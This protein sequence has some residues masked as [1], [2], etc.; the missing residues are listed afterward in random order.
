[1]FNIYFIKDRPLTEGPEAPVPIT[2]NEWEFNMLLEVYKDKHPLNVLEVGTHY[3]GTLYHW[4][5][6]SS[7]FSSIVSVDDYQLNE[8][9]YA[10]WIDNPDCMVHVVKGKSQDKNVISSVKRIAGNYDFIFIDA[11]HEYEEVKADW[12]NYGPLANAGSIV[13]FHDITPHKFRGVD[14]LWREI[15]SAGYVTQEL[16]TPGADLGIGIVYL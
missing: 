11:G 13:A 15:Q 6:N 4:I 3:G 2:Q 9:L 1:M 10:D 7:A 12:E 14:K 8:H 16:I 5:K